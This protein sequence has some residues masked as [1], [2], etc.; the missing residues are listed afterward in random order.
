[1]AEPGEHAAVDATTSRTWPLNGIVKM[2]LALA[3]V[4]SP[5]ALGLLM[6]LAVSTVQISIDYDSLPGTPV[7]GHVLAS[8]LT[9][10][11]GVALG[12]LA[13]P[14]ALPKVWPAAARIQPLRR[15]AASV[16]G[17]AAVRAAAI[18]VKRVELSAGWQFSILVEPLVLLFGTALGAAVVW[19]VL[20][21][22]E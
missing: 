11:C 2:Q 16:L 4:W 1:M 20:R 22:K 17:P 15:V 18:L 3:C 14:I 9:Y 13:T 7:G 19:P 21:A 6:V 8:E 10:W 12:M 5:Y